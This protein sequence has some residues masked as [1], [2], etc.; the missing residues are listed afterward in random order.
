M[1]GSSNDAPYESGADWEKDVAAPNESEG[2]KEKESKEL[3][4]DPQESEADWEKEL[5][6]EEIGSATAFPTL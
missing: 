4:A 1:I 5:E 6:L 2:S 3:E